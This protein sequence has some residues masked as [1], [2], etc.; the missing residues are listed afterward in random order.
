MMT[1]RDKQG[2]EMN[3]TRMVEEAIKG[4]YDPTDLKYLCA[5]IVMENCE[6]DV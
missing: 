5:S 1:D 3:L 6:E 4:G 2:F